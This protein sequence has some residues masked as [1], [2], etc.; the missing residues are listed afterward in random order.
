[1]QSR[2]KELEKEL[3]EAE[4]TPTPTPTTPELERD[5]AT[6]YRSAARPT[7]L[8]VLVA[9]AETNLQI[10]VAKA[11]AA[12][13]A[14]ATAIVPFHASAAHTRPQ[15]EERRP[16]PR[17]QVIYHSVP[18]PWEEYDE[19]QPRRCPSPPPSRRVERYRTSYKEQYDERP[20]RRR[21][22]RR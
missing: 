13:V 8:F 5:L 14:E 9:Q 6:R 20:P 18:H 10:E 7:K 21:R 12:G 19:Y 1:M 15:Y 22:T 17:P 3:E 4:P 11:R 16:L 2:V